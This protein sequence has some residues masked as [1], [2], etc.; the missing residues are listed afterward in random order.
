LPI[1][2]YSD[3]DIHEDGVCMTSRAMPGSTAALKPH[4]LW[5]SPFATSVHK[6]VNT[7]TFDDTNLA[8]LS[9]DPSAIVT[10]YRHLVQ[11]GKSAEIDLCPL[12]N[13]DPAD[14]LWPKN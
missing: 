6:H 4:S 7:R 10:F 8:L 2:D 9:H 13:F 5:I 1:L 12:N 14:C 11:L 3:E